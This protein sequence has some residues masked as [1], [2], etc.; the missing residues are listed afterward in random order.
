[1]D[2]SKYF[3]SVVL[4]LKDVYV[5]VL[6]GAPPIFSKY[7]IPSKLAQVPEIVKGFVLRKF[8]GAPVK[9]KSPC[10]NTFVIN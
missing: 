9:K 3:L 10:I 4:H 1:M 6:T 7:K 2:Q 8:R 5:L